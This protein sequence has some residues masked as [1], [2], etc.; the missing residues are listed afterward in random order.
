M[1]RK[2]EAAGEEEKEEESPEYARL[3]TLVKDVGLS[4]PTLEE[5]FMR[6]TSKKERKSLM[7]TLA[8]AA[9]ISD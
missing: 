1:E 8:A 4:H 2:S 6:V 7:E 9:A 3:K 5:V